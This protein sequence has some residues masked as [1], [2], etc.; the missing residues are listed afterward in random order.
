MANDNREWTA[1]SA[2]ILSSKK[3]SSSMEKEEEEKAEAG[4]VLS[5][6]IPY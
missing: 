4:P 3:K 5:I 6:K 1:G 2:P